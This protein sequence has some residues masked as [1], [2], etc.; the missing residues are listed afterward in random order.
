MQEGDELSV[1]KVILRILE[2]PGHTPESISI[3]VVDT[4]VS[5]EPQKVLTGDTLFIG[6]V[7]RPDLVGSKGYSS[8]E[9]AEM[10]YDSLH[11]KLLKLDDAV[12]VYPAHGAGSCAAATCRRK[13]LR[14]SVSS[15]NSTML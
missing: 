14:R 10:L 4:E 5:N 6:D 9:M 1:G 8:E 7:G 3:F 12:E 2:T 13:R 11:G 15:E